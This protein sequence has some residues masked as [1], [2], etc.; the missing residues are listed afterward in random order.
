MDNKELLMCNSRLN[1]KEHPTRLTVEMKTLCFLCTFLVVSQLFVVLGSWVWS[2]AMPESNVRSLLSPAGMRWFFGS[3]VSNLASPFL[4]WIVLLDIA[5]GICVNSGLWKCIC[6]RFR[7]WEKGGG[8]AWDYQQKTGL[9]AVLVFFIVEIVVLLMLTLPRHAVL[10]S[11]TGKFFP[12][13]FSVSIVPVMAFIIATLSFLYG[14]FSG[15]L[16]N[17]QEMVKCACHGGAWL[18]SILVV[19]VLAMELYCSVVYVLA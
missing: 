9:N 13:S 6:Q 7:F 12:S 8:K 1:C 15:L 19:Y 17:Y 5:V 3:F 2:A 4:V 14:L 18:K 11:A 10:L 16:H